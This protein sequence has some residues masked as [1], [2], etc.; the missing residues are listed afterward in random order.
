M[1]NNWAWVLRHYS[2][3]ELQRRQDICNQ[4]IAIAHKTGNTVGLE[5]CQAMANTLLGVIM[6]KTKCEN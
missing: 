3:K 6:E 1:N 4:Q 5:R 2:L